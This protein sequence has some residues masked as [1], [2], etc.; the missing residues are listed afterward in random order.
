MKLTNPFDRTGSPI[1]KLA[2]LA[3]AVVLSFQVADVSCTKERPPLT[4]ETRSPEDSLN[5]VAQDSISSGGETRD[6]SNTPGEAKSD[7]EKITSQPGTDNKDASTG[8]KIGDGTPSTDEAGPELDD[9]D[10]TG[11]ESGSP[12]STPA[13]TVSEEEVGAYDTRSQRIEKSLRLLGSMLDSQSK[14]ADS[15]INKAGVAVSQVGTP[16]PS[17]DRSVSLEVG[18]PRLDRWDSLIRQVCREKG[19]SHPLFVKALLRVESNG[20]PSARNSQSTATGLLQTVVPTAQQVNSALEGRPTEQVRRLLENPE[21]SVRTGVEYL[22]DYVVPS[23]SAGNTEVSPDFLPRV[24]RMYYLGHHLRLP[25][26]NDNIPPH[27]LQKSD[28]YVGKVMQYYRRWKKETG[29]EGA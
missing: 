23:A 15:L 2:A 19:F 17:T 21:T 26:G 25:L 9:K 5:T 14:K 11:S 22:T 12:G 29:R 28:S 16:L 27:L 1:W 20:N 10:P 13:R 6:S 18:I 24:A 3:L 7:G 8:P 4:T